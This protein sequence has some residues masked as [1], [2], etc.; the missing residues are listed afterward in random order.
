MLKRKAPLTFENALSRA[1]DLCARCEQCS[2]DI[3]KKLDSWGINASDSAKI[4]RR[5]EDL[6]FLDN[7]RFAKAY[8]HDKLHFSGWGR[9]KI[10]QGLWAKRL[11]TDIID[12][13]FDDI[14]EEDDEYRAIALRV[15]K[16]K[17]RQL[18]EWPLSRESKLK[19][20]KFAMT[21]GFEYPLIV[22]I[23]RTEIARMTE[24]ENQ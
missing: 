22:D 14:D 16:A 15:M 6:K 12:H 23:F 1:A 2:P 9:R 19:V 20:V 11:P 13:A 24:D 17:I 21:R 5:L 4:I 7:L 10:R 18:K 8:A 3:L